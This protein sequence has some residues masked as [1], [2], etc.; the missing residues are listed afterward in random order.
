MSIAFFMPTSGSFYQKIQE[1]SSF[2]EKVNLCIENVDEFSS[3]IK[4]F[5]DFVDVPLIAVW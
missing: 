4:K 1:A 2:D 3:V 5:H